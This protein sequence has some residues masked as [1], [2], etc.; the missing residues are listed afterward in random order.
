MKTIGISCR[1]SANS[2]CRPGPVIPGMAMSRIRHLVWPTQSDARNSSG[3]ENARAAN[4]NSLS[5]SGSDSRTHSSSSTTDT[6]ESVI[7]IDFLAHP[8][9]LASPNAA[10][11]LGAP[12]T[13]GSARNGE[14]KTRLGGSPS[15]AVHL[16]MRHSSGERYCPLVL[17][18]ADIKTSTADEDDRDRLKNLTFID[19]S[20]SIR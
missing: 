17:V 15:A 16:R 8:S 3:D 14:M 4:P 13:L 2:L 12:Q 11:V 9:R 10:T 1:R 6:S 20:R 7:F 19:F 18:G 5:K